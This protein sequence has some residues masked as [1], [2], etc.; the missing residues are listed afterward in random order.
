MYVLNNKLTVWSFVI[1]NWIEVNDL[2][3]G[4]YSTNKNIGFNTPR[5]R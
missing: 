5:L 4:Q 3:D 2:S 1:K